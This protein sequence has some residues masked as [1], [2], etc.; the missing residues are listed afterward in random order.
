MI[1]I[2]LKFGFGI[3]KIL[4]IICVKN[5]FFVINVGN[6]FINGDVIYRSIVVWWIIR[7]GIMKEWDVLFII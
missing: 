3:G 5:E 1:R 6:S 7:F 4:G 2:G